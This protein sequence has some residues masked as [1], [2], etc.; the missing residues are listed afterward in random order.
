MFLGAIHR[1]PQ[2]GATPQHSLQSY[3]GGC[4]KACSWKG[5][6]LVEFHYD[7]AKEDARTRCWPQALVTTA[8]L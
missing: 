4:Q 5:D 3:L 2:G 1:T 6:S 7:T 8:C